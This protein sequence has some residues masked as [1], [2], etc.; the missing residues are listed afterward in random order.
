[1]KT[2]CE[3]FQKVTT[4]PETV[5]KSNH[6]THFFMIA[7]RSALPMVWPSPSNWNDAAVSEEPGSWNEVLVFCFRTSTVPCRSIRYIPPECGAHPEQAL[8][9]AAQRPS[10]TGL[11]GLGNGQSRALWYETSKG[12]TSALVLKRGEFELGAVVCDR[13]W[14]GSREL[15]GINVWEIE[16][17]CAV[18]FWSANAEVAGS[19]EKGGDKKKVLDGQKRRKLSICMICIAEKLGGFIDKGV[20]AFFFCRYT[21]TP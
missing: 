17:E 13:R 18:R 20:T 19:R 11:G 8:L 7:Y 10:W 2:L 12:C 15:I 14:E 16:V 5:A 3:A 1:M 4:K 6:S 9:G 21:S